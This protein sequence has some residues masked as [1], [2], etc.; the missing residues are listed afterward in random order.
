MSGPAG[1]GS[2]PAQG[3]ASPPSSAPH[4]WPSPLPRAHRD[5]LEEVY[6]RCTSFCLPTRSRQKQTQA[7]PTHPQR[8]ESSKSDLCHHTAQHGTET[9][10][11]RLRTGQPDPHGGTQ[12]HPGLLPRSHAPAGGS[13]I[14]A[15][16]LRPGRSPA[17][18]APHPGRRPISFSTR[19]LTVRRASGRAVLASRW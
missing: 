10:T 12:T 17:G 1:R 11:Q 7:A 19:R 5:S 14:L 8:G 16:I 9:N 3:Q 6:C 18:R 4:T 15:L 2:P 13:R